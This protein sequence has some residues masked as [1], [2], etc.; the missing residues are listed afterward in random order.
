[1]NG[2][3]GRAVRASSQRLRPILGQN[4]DVNREPPETWNQNLAE[5]SQTSAR[6]AKTGTQGG[7]VPR[8]RRNHD[9]WQSGGIAFSGARRHPCKRTTGNLRIGR[10]SRRRKPAGKPSGRSVNGRSRAL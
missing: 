5:V 8:R 10:F 3:F 1:M 4:R 6:D 9:D 2:G 7:T